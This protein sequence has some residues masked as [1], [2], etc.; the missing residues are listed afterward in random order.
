[1]SLLTF[2]RHGNCHVYVDRHADLAMAEDIVVNAKCQRPGVCNAA[3]TLLV[4]AKIATEFLPNA[5]KTLRESGVELRGCPRTCEIVSD[6]QP[7]TED[8]W[9]T[10]YLSLTIAVK[11]VDDLNDAIEHIGC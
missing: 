8:D 10:E 1:M 4:H 7:A 5:A 11:V 9:R 2:T 3:E 6:C